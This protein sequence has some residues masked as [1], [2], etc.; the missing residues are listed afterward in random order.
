M[1]PKLSAPRLLAPEAGRT[2]PRAYGAS[3]GWTTVPGAKAYEWELQ[4]EV[5]KDEWETK[6][7]QTVN[8]NQFRPKRLEKGRFRWRVRAIRDGVEGA[9]SDFRRLYA[10]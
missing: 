10:Y 2:A 5:G 9:W 4:A 3:F 6:D 8:A 7:T 1:P